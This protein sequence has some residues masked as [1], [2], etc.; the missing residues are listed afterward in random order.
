MVKILGINAF[1]GDASAALIIDGQLVAAVEEER[2]N[3]IKHA[4]GFPAESIRY[5]LKAGGVQLSDL[6]H[7]A[8]S[9]NPSA[10]IHK[11]LLFS[12]KNSP[13]LDL[14]KSRL[15]NASR[16]HDLKTL[17][18]QSL[19]VAPDGIKAKLHNIE[20]HRAHLAS[21]FFVSPFEKAALLSVDGFGDFV[22][23]MWGIGNGSK[24]EIDHW[25]EFPHSIGILYTA[26]TQFLG[27][28]KYGDEYKVMG[29]SSYG[30]PEYAD[31]MKTL[32]Q[33]TNGLSYKLNLDYFVHHSQGVQMTWDSGYP[34]MS[35]VYADS[36]K[37]LLGE[38]RVAQSSVEPRHQNIAM[39]LQKHL[40]ETLFHMLNALYEKTHCENLCMAGGVALNCV[41]NGKITDR[42]P[43][44]H[45]YIQ[46]AAND[47]GTAIGAAF[48]VWNALLDQPRKFQMNHAFWG[49][50]YSDTEIE[51]AINSVAPGVPACRPEN[52]CDY[53]AQQLEAGKVV[54]WYQ[55]RM[56]FG[57]R[58]LGNRSILVDPRRAEMKDVLNAR[59]KH[60]EPF[61]PFAP[62]I[63]EEAI[64]S[65]FEKSDPSPFMLMTYNVLHDKR[66]TIPAPTHVDG[67]GRLQ[68]I[69]RDQN[70]LYWDLLDAF[71]RRTG[72]PVLLNTSF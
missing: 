14:I 54:G 5:C 57:P 8:V 47:S 16:I 67:T 45:I 33:A 48:Y 41:A 28:P 3:R 51:S 53:T 21:S 44:R 9:R 31:Q 22:S 58:A 18:A 6:D 40:E 71:E 50:E 7:I 36:L 4:A 69:T 72:V 24:I 2:F 12:L 19:D 46:P 32:L 60:R 23:A 39:S 68:T 65:Y 10:H 52:L 11:K 34:E 43:F 55:G 20:H 38:P 49:P 25:V 17:L 70:A 37:T 27:F 66:N 42:T 30:E 1:H 59:I 35:S 62:V 61:R 15:S 64:G 29:L 13:S 56:E 63:K 26:I